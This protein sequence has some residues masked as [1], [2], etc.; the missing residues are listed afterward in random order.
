ML[1]EPLE[2]GFDETVGGAV[3]LLLGVG[4]LCFGTSEAVV[5]DGGVI[6]GVI[7]ASVGGGGDDRILCRLIA[8]S[9]GSVD[10][11]SDGMF[12]DSS[13]RTRAAPSAVRHPIASRTTICSI[14]S[15]CILKDCLSC[16][17]S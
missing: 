1:T 15:L 8:D 9:S 7:A 4:S 10:E 3:A 2:L 14:N 6:D 12:T 13:S 16:R 17:F 11:D 5:L